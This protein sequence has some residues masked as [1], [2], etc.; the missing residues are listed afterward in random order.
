M[1]IRDGYV[2]N[3]PIF[4]S[5]KAILLIVA[6][7]NLNLVFFCTIFLKVP[8]E[9]STQMITAILFLVGIGVGVQGGIDM[10]QSNRSTF[11]TER[12]QREVKI[13]SDMHQMAYDEFGGAYDHSEDEYG[14]KD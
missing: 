1:N 3:K 5:K 9:L 8:I 12:K 10:I 13:T 2:M 11:I 7:S 4:K 6:I 14:R